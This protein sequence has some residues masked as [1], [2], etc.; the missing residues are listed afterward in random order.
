MTIPTPLSVTRR[1]LYQRTVTTT[2]YAC[3]SCPTGEIDVLDCT[4]DGSRY[5]DAYDLDP[6]TIPC[7]RCGETDVEAGT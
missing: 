5:R 3:P 7:P 1:H 2:T 4:V 6:Q